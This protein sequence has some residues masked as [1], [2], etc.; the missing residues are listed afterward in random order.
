MGHDLQRE[1]HRDT[2]RERETN[3][4]RC[5]LIMRLGSSLEAKINDIFNF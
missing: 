5:Y 3:L 4:M 1:T 2:H